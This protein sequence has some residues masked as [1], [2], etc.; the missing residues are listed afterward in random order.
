VGDTGGNVTII[1][2]VKQLVRPLSDDTES[3]FE[4]GDD[5]QETLI[6]I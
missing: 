4:E 3:I 5:D 1:L 2:Q 6:V